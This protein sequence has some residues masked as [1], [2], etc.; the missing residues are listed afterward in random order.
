MALCILFYF[1]S[2]SIGVLGVWI[3]DTWVLPSEHFRSISDLALQISRGSSYTF[4]ANVSV[5]GCTTSTMSG[6]YCNQTVNPLSCVLSDS[7]NFTESLSIDNQTTENFISCRSSFENSCHV[8]GEP[9]IY[10]LDVM[11]LPEQLSVTVM[12]V[13]FNGTSSNFTGNV[14]EINVMCLARHGTIP[15]PNL[16]DYSTNINKAPLVIRSPKVGRWYF[17]ILP[18]NL[19]KE[20]GG[21]QDPTIKVCYSMEWKVLECPLGKAGLNCTQE[22]YMLQVGCCLICV[23]YYSF[24]CL[25][26]C[27]LINCCF[28]Q[29]NLQQ[30]GIHW[31]IGLY[32]S[33]L[34]IMKIWALGWREYYLT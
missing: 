22:R 28:Y 13:R 18:V 17:T 29:T 34:L 25:N 12:N 19:S 32:S 8:D 31:L 6:Q 5:E 1:F 27:L 30:C 23:Y 20:I 21:I 7:S 24:S 14:S 11:G 33:C 4:S 10:F 3:W 16:H 26:H 15:L 9:K 2:F